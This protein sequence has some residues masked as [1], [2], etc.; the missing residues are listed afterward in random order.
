MLRR[1]DSCLEECIGASFAVVDV[2]LCCGVTM[3]KPKVAGE[4]N[5]FFGR[6]WFRHRT[7]GCD[8]TSSHEANDSTRTTCRLIDESCQANSHNKNENINRGSILSPLATDAS[9]DRAQQ[10]LPMVSKK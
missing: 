10:H 2:D 7:V 1:E 9:L 6:G 3:D 4:W 8:D 5:G